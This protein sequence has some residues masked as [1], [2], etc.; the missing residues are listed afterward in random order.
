MNREEYKQRKARAM[1]LMADDF[2]WLLAQPPGRYEWLASKKWLIEWANDVGGYRGAV[3]EMLRP[4]PVCRLYER[5]FGVLG[6]TLPRHPA[7]SLNKLRMQEKRNDVSPDYVILYYMN[8]LEEVSPEDGEI[9][10]RTSAEEPLSRIIGHLLRTN[11]AF[12]EP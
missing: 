12:F 2:D 9:G 5:C 8:H 11:E 7:T 6:V 3:D 1:Q 4:I 10:Q